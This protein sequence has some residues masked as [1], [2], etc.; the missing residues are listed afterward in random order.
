MVIVLGL[1]LLAIAL[2]FWRASEARKEAAAEVLSKSEFPY[3]AIPVDRVAPTAVDTIAAVPG[4]V[5]LAAYKDKIVV[6]ARAGLFQI[7]RASCRERV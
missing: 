6:S 2:V 3:R 4:F 5:D 7:G 1:P